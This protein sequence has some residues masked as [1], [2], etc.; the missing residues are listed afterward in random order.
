MVF[1]HSHGE[2]DETGI[3]T[4]SVGRDL[5]WLMVLESTMAAAVVTLNV[6]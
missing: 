3:T 4:T 5:F 1:Y 6:T 2:V